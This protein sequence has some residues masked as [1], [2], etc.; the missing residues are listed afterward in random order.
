M[1]TLTQ[2]PHRSWQVNILDEFLSIITSR[3]RRPLM[4]SVGTEWLSSGIVPKLLIRLFQRLTPKM[5]YLTLQR[6]P[7]RIILPIGRMYTALSRI[8]LKELRNLYGKLY[9]DGQTI[10]RTLWFIGV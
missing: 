1:R 3:T 4:S 10:L 8:L 5:L 2:T 7:L 6:T 9:K